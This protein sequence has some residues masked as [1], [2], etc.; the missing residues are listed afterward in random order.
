MRYWLETYRARW[1]C[2]WQVVAVA[3]FWLVECSYLPQLYR[4]YQRKTADEIS[5]LFPTMNLV[6][7]LLLVG[8][9]LHAG[10]AVLALGFMFGVLVR[11]VFLGEVTYYRRKRA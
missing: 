8:Y 6:G 3:A 2:L 11:A 5:V 7:R 1:D 4:L 9:S 10:T